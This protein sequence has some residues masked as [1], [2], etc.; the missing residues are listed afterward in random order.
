MDGLNGALF[1]QVPVFLV[2]AGVVALAVWYH[3]GAGLPQRLRAPGDGRLRMRLPWAA[4]L[5]GVWFV[6]TV[7]SGWTVFLIG[8]LL[9]HVLL[10]W[11]G[12]AAAAVGL[13]ALALS[14]I[15]LPFLWG[16]AIFTPA[17]R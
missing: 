5:I 9:C 7:V 14:L 17:L 10:F 11:V 1:F 12:P 8:G 13:V 16:W 3:S 2:A 6:L 4:G 15:S